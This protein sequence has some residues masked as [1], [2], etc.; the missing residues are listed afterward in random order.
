MSI[1]RDLIRTP[2]DSVR[3]DVGG[4]AAPDQVPAVESR[5]V[6][7]TQERLTVPDAM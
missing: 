6:E 7:P 1:T 5:A 3:L 2:V 4:I